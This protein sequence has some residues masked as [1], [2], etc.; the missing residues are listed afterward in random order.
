MVVNSDHCSFQQE[1][2][3]PK[4]LSFTG[5]RTTE[6]ADAQLLD[7]FLLILREKKM[8]VTKE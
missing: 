3:S 6:I 1:Y 7:K 4:M 5:E 2:V 8:N